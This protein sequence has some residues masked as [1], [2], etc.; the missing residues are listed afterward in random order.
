MLRMLRIAGGRVTR[1]CPVIESGCRGIITLALDDGVPTDLLLNTLLPVKL[2]AS[3]EKRCLCCLL[4]SV[5]PFW[6]R[7]GR[8]PPDPAEAVEFMVRAG[9]VVRLEYAI[10]LAVSL[11]LTVNDG[12]I[13]GDEALSNAGSISNG[14]RA[15]STETKVS[16]RSPV[17]ETGRV[18]GGTDECGERSVDFVPALRKAGGAAAAGSTHGSE[19]L[20]SIEHRSVVSTLCMLFSFILLG[21]V[22][23]EWSVVTTTAVALPTMISEPFTM[24]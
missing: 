6:L 2:W 10:F 23:A 19:V 20:P 24:L 12:S 14:C 3:L 5:S 8:S 16:V 17:C 4:V 13:L 18:G 11:L 1:R 9:E 22:V 21:A 15:G 7:G